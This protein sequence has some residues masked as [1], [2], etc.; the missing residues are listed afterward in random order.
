MASGF[1]GEGIYQSLV[2][3]K[4]VAEAILGKTDSLP[5]MEAVLK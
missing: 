4:V 2:S 3:G 5:E 1:T